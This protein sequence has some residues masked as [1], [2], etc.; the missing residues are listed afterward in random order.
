M[1]EA[2]KGKKYDHT[3]KWMVEQEPQGFFAWLMETLGRQG[4]ILKEINVSKELAPQARYVDLVWRILT[5][6]GTEAL[7]H[8]EL[9]LDPD[10]TMGQRMLEYAMRLYERDHLPV[11]S[12]IIWL[13]RAGGLPT[14]PFIVYLDDEE[15]LRYPYREQARKPPIFSRGMNGPTLRSWQCIMRCDTLLL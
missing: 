8:I 3:L 5:P 2:I 9:Q 14:P 10:S 4:F 13:K 6:K 1:F 11:L 7:L 15:W 12:V